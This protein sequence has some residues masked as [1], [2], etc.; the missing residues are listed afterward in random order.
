MYNEHKGA[1]SDDFITQD[2]ILHEQVYEINEIIRR[3][4][5]DSKERSSPKFNTDLRFSRK[6]KGE[7]STHHTNYGPYLDGIH[8]QTT[9]GPHLDVED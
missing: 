6:D 2:A 1:D 4:P 7:S 3:L 5:Y 8:P 9:F